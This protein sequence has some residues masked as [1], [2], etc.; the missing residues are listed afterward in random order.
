MTTQVKLGI[1]AVA[2]GLLG[3]GAYVASAHEMPANDNRP[4][5]A[6]AAHDALTAGDYDAWKAAHE[7]RVAEMTTPER[8]ADMQE[9]HRLRSEGKVDEARA[10]AEEHGLRGM[11]GHGKRMM[12]GEGRGY[13]GTQAN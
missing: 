8:F 7:A 12:N 4:A 9:M 1:V 10:Y 13:R 2:L 5:W 6:T 11:G 3:T